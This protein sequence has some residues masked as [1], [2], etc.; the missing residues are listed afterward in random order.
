MRFAA[1]LGQPR[2]TESLTRALDSGRFTP[3]LIF[4]GPAGVGKLATALV[5]CRNL[6]CTISGEPP[7]DDCRACRRI[8]EGSLRHPDIRVI[9]PEKLSEFQKGDRWREDVS[10]IDLQDKQAEAIRNPVWTI[11]IDRVRQGRAFLQRRPSEGRHAVLL[12]DQAHRMGAEA[13]NALLKILEEPPE[14]AVLIL[15]TTS[16]HA[17]LPTIRSRCQDLGF[18]LVPTA[19]IARFLAARGTVPAEEIELRASLSG[20][21][22]GAA[23]ELD[24]DALRARRETLLDLLES[25]IARGDAGLAVAGAEAI[26]R[27][28]DSLEHDLRI[29]MALLRDL[30]VLGAGGGSESALVNPDLAAR[31]RELVSDAGERTPTLVQELESSIEGIRRKGNRQLLVENFLLGMVA[32]GGTSTSS[33]PS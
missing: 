11:L 15:L 31:L 7:C 25:L 4:H 30:M 8:D 6:L 12:V 23:L 3:S 33:H 28:S 14:H 26:A 20:G 32:P 10:G 18:Q 16:L 5:L 29:M 27:K 24:L 9:F 21:R 13:A 17:L 22:L 2:A 19:Q 1:I